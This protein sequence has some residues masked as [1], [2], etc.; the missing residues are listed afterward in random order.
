MN[1]LLWVTIYAFVMAPQIMVSAQTDV[2]APGDP[3]Q[4]VPNDGDW[5]NNPSN[6]ETP[7][8]AIDNDSSTKFLHFKGETQPTGIAV[9]PA[10]PCVVGGIT[11]TTANDAV[12]RDPA[13]Y[14]LYGTNTSIDAP[15]PDWTLIHSDS[16]SLPDTRYTKVGPILFDNNT[17]YAHY[18]LLFPTVKNPGSANSMQIAEIELIEKPANGWPPV[19]DAGSDATL[20]YPAT[21]LTLS[22]T[23]S[24]DGLP[25]PANPTAPDP[26]DPHKLRWSWSVKSKPAASEGVQWLGN[27][28]SGEAFTYEGSS[29]PPGTIF[30]CNPTAQ[31]D[32]EGVYQLE[33]SATDDNGDTVVTDSVFIDVWPSGYRDKGYL[34]LSPL[35]GAENVRRENRF[36]L[37]RLE[38][39]LP[40]EITNLSDFMSVVGSVSGNHPGQTKIA[41]DNRTIIFE[42]ES[43]FTIG[44]TV[45]VNLIPEVDPGSAGTLESYQYRFYV[46]TYAGAAAA[47]VSAGQLTAT[48][49]PDHIIPI[50]SNVS[51]HE[52]TIQA[53]PGEPTIMANGVSVPSTFP[54]LEVTINNN[55]SPGYIFLER[56]SSPQYAMIVDSN[57]D[58]VW[59]QQSRARDLK[60]QHDGSITH[61]SNNAIYS[62]DLEFHGYDENFNRTK[63]YRPVNGYFTDDHELQVLAD[64]GY[65]I[66]GGG[67]MSV[68]M[69]HYASG[70]NPNASVLENVLQEFT[71]EGDLIFQWRSWDH[72][73]ILD[74]NELASSI[75]FPH[76]NAIDVDDD[77]NL[78]VSSRHISE[79]TKINRDTGDIIWRLS[80]AHN[81]FT[82]INDT[83]NGVSYQHDIR[84]LGNHHYTIFDNG[85]GHSPQ[86]SRAVEYEINTDTMEATVVWEFRDS[87]DKYA[88]YMGNAQRLPNG[89]TLINFVSAAYPKAIEV[90]P[91]GQKVFEMSFLPGYSADTYR[92]FKFP[93]TG[94]VEKPLLILEAQSDNITLI[95]YKFGDHN[96][97]YYR[98]Y[99]GASPNPTTVLQ[100]SQETLAQVTTGLTPDVVNYFRVTAVD[101]QGNESAFSNEESAMVNFTV[102]GTNM[103]VNGDFSQ[104]TNSWIFD[105]DGSADASWSVANEEARVAITNGGTLLSDVQLYQ[106]GLPI[107]QGKKYTLEFDARSTPAP[108]LIEVKVGQDDSD[109][110]KIGP[111]Q[112]TPNQ[113]TYRYT[114]TMNDL[115]DNDARLMFDLGTY[116]YDVYL[117][118]ISLVN[119]LTCE[120]VIAMGKNLFGDFDANCRIDMRDFMAFMSN[121]LRCVDPQDVNCDNPLQQP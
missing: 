57:G 114:F 16:L 102:P 17:T 43:N 3:I 42:A 53:G 1:K 19:V 116:T 79:I 82:F 77:G 29:N 60:V 80:G 99:S 31:F 2:T 56:M 81:Q 40:N 14:A 51:A 38:T 44:E 28:S 100:T 62:Y 87:P 72:Y 93:W 104:G 91:G 76:M 48:S 121:W 78:V 103:V 20:A 71:A 24:D 112:I 54:W 8:M 11:L 35:P 110:S 6:V 36:L 69:S 88:S 21:L 5:P 64:G 101:Y 49:A 9:T 97:D 73:D 50:P 33:F 52:P 61:L 118:N 41:S 113:A 23:V 90:T 65:L 84:A 96:V 109:Y 115:T 86:V 117:D 106:T 47:P 59:Y 89:N 94:V 85:N 13:S 111:V 39:V 46:N 7:P 22:G 119:V 98:I 26:D 107:L 120:D 105:L 74:L 30:T 108:R 32:V 95:F 67:F 68:D 12:E 55:P 37:V 92:V 83:F 70:G 66:I 45:S 63:T 10:A 15:D 4:G 58:P 75:D 25:L 27:P 34:Y 18:R